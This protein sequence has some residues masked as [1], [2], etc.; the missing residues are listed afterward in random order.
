MEAN[1]LRVR[2]RYA[3]LEAVQE[4]NTKVKPIFANYRPASGWVRCGEC[5]FRTGE[6]C[7]LVRGAITEHDVCDLFAAEVES[8][9][10]GALAGD[11][12]VYQP[13]E[14]REQ[15]ARP[16]DESKIK[17]G[18][19]KT[20][21]KGQFAPKGSGG[22]GGK[23]SEEK[24]EAKA[25]VEKPAAG[26]SKQQQPKPQQQQPVPQAA[27]QQP[28]AQPATRPGVAALKPEHEQPPQ[29]SPESL[30]R[31]D[32]LL[33]QPPANPEAWQ[34]TWAA[35]ERHPYYQEV[36]SRMASY[37]EDS[38]NGNVMEWSRGKHTGQDGNYT[39]ERQAVHKEILGRL[40]N[41]KAKAKPGKRPIAVFLMGPPAA[42]KTTAGAPLTSRL[43]VEFTTINP[44]DVKEQLP[45]YRGWNAGLLHEESSDVAEGML[46]E[47]A[48]E[49]QHNVMF[50]ITGKNARKVTDE[51]SAL[52]AAGYD[53]HVVNVA[54]D[55]HVV[56]WR[57]WQ[58]F[59]RQAFGEKKGR[60]VPPKYAAEAVDGKP[61][62]TFEA[63]KQHPAVKG[64]FSADTSG[65]ER[66]EGARI[67]EEGSK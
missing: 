43:G 32:A 46:R 7:Q 14:Q 55:N 2:E 50:D 51:A 28:A 54:A 48:V 34:Q 23:G 45:E 57:A 24:P 19:P 58:R 52:Q 65:F 10:Q 22:V 39:P 66:G 56:G 64:W 41:P 15:Y 30:A 9:I 5:R 60:F 44:D 37:A 1:I 35:I 18:N 33:A 31:A 13:R 26:P 47:Q 63:M 4:A 11:P 25:A 29:V 59:R 42:G 6:A 27:R 20:G 21:N 38:P 3:K 8:G 67:I 40:L 49:A 16:F 17:R 53:V 62:Q 12:R 36:N 61:K